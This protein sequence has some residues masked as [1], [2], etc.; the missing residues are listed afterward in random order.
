MYRDDWGGRTLRVLDLSTLPRGFTQ[1]LHVRKLKLTLVRE[2][3]A[4]SVW[5]RCI[6]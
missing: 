5:T 2:V 4:E 6:E 1:A 3:V